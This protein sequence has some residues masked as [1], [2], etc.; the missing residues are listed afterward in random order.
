MQLLDHVSISVHS[1]DAVRSFYEST[2]SALGA[3]KVFDQSGAI[4]FGA[5]CTPLET[6]HTYLAVYESGSVAVADKNHLCFK[7]STRAQVRAFYEA[8]LANGGRDYGA[9]GLRAAYHANYYGAYLIDPSGNRIEAVCHHF[10]P[11][12]EGLSSR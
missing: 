8:G 7:A 9:P 10:E 5:R 4:G 6:M 11:V 2:M 3:A 1:I 12:I